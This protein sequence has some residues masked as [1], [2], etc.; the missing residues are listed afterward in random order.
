M[1]VDMRI[2]TNYSKNYDY[3]APPPAAPIGQERGTAANG[4]FGEGNC[5]RG[6]HVEP[7]APCP[8]G[9]ASGSSVGPGQ[10]GKEPA[11]VPLHTAATLEPLR[12]TSLC[13]P[14]DRSDISFPSEASVHLEFWRLVQIGKQKKRTQDDMFAKI[15]KSSHTDRAQLNA[16]RQTTGESRK[17][18]HEYEERRDAHDKSTQDATVKLMG[19][20]TDMLC[21]KV[22]LMQERQQDQTAASAPV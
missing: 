19:E 15:M 20:Q 5:R 2:H 1:K 21:C 12:Y 4:S 13:L 14:M 22:D 3:V 18:L 17:V 10:A 16:W 11:L 6:Q 7:S 9:A 8:P